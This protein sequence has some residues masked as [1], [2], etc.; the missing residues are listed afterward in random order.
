VHHDLREPLTVGRFDTVVTDPPYTTAGAKL[1]LTRAVEALAGVGSSIFLSFGSRR[2]GVQFELQRA[3][4][5]ARLEIRSLTRDFNDYV[6][7]GVLGGTSHL[8]H[9][10]AAPPADEEDALYTGARRRIDAT[11]STSRRPARRS[12]AH[13]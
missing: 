5:L 6:G 1:F 10:A 13:Q 4:A 3:I 12:A 11:P 8:Y 7:A 2:P 9:L